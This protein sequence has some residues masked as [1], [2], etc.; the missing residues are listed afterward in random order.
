[1]YP[2]PGTLWL[3][4]RTEA[5]PRRLLELCRRLLVHLTEHR[6]LYALRAHRSGDCRTV[7]F[8][9]LAPGRAWPV[10]RSVELRGSQRSLSGRGLCLSVD[11]VP[12][13]PALLMDDWLDLP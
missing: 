12:G 10:H 11:Q 3:Q 6:H 8:L 13:E 4:A 1:R 9:E 2:R 7:L 5:S